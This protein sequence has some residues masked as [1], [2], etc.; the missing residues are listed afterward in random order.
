M[1]RKDLAG[2][3]PASLWVSPRAMA[4]GLLGGQTLHWKK[5]PYGKGSHGWILRK[6]D[7]MGVPA[8][9]MATPPHRTQHVPGKQAAWDPYLQDGAPLRLAFHVLTGLEH[10]Q[11]DAVQEDDQHADVL[12]PGERRALRKAQLQ[13]PSI[14]RGEAE[15][16]HHL[17]IK[18]PPLL[19]K[20][21]KKTLK[22]I[23]DLLR[24]K[25]FGN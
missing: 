4:A 25:V 6:R 7:K 10:A 20:A 13:R 3:S 16:P 21:Q 1:Q 17:H 11:G 18:K 22:N 24:F 12:E 14:G 2:V 15:A 23:T 9:R 19:P 5:H 8:P